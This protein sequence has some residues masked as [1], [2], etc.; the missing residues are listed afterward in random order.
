MLEA[1]HILCPATSFGDLAKVT[2]EGLANAHLS[3]WSALS[4]VEV[5]DVKIFDTQHRMA[6]KA[7][8][9]DV[10]KLLSSYDNYSIGPNSAYPMTLG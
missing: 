5:D 8:E 7:S 6:F 9:E 4:D 2:R 3:D 10:F 1:L